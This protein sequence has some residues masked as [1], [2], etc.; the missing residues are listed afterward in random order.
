VDAAISPRQGGISS[1]TISG[2]G[3]R[4]RSP[5]GASLD[6]RGPG[7]TRTRAESPGESVS[8][9][10]I[11]W[12]G[13]EDPVL[14]AE[15]RYE[16]V[17]DRTDFLFPSSRTVGESDGWGKYGIDDGDAPRGRAALP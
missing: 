12:C 1:S 16:G 7:H 6:S 15:F 17:T 11:R 10:V 8:R 14:Q 9:A 4:R 2:S 3:P 5:V 13:F